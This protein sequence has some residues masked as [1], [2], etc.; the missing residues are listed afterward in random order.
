MLILLSYSTL[1]ETVEVSFKAPKFKVNYRAIFTKY[2]NIFDPWI[3]N[4]KDLIGEKRKNN[5]F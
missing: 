3:Y 2:Q 1:T 4:N 5:C